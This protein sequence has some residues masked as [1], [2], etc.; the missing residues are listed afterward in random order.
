[1]R[2]LRQ[3]LHLRLE[4][5]ATPGRNPR[6]AEGIRLDELPK[7]RSQVQDEESSRK[8]LQSSPRGSQAFWVIAIIFYI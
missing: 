2:H 1:M 7:L 3:G 4:L 5:E 6:R 8:T